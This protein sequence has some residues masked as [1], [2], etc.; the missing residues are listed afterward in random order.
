MKRFFSLFYSWANLNWEWTGIPSVL[1]WLRVQL[2]KWGIAEIQHL[3]GLAS[4][5]EQV[6]GT[7]DQDS[8]KMAEQAKTKQAA[9][10]ELRSRGQN[11]LDVAVLVLLDRRV[12]LHGRII[13]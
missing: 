7:E 9:M 11:T 10:K 8:S 6:L 5:L 2:G 3:E 12:Q 1:Q 13:F 4:Q